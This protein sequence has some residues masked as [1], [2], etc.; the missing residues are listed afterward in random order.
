M[1]TVWTILNTHSHSTNLDTFNER[2]IDHRSPWSKIQLVQSSIIDLTAMDLNR[3]ARPKSGFDKKKMYFESN[4]FSDAA[5]RE[6]HDFDARKDLSDQSENFR[7]VDME[8]HD[9]G[10][11]IATNKSFVIFVSTSLN[12][13]SLR[14]VHI[15]ESNLLHA[16]KL[17]SLDDTLLIGLTDGSVKVLR[18]TSSNACRKSSDKESKTEVGVPFEQVNFNAKSCA[19]QNIIKEERKQFDDQAANDRFNPLEHVIDGADIGRGNRLINNQ[20]LLPAMS[21]NRDFVRWMD[22]SVN[23]NC[24]ISLC[25]ERLRVINIESTVEDQVGDSRE[26]AAFATMVL[27]YN[28]REYLVSSIFG[29]FFIEIIYDEKL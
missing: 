27:G 17:K 28:Q 2:R 7:C 21:S 13:G 14:K 8:Y 15:D 4:L 23:L 19:I 20:I 11:V 6:L 12:R 26:G 25:G 9:D 5:L 1:V 3:K 16:T 10:I 22:V 29:K 18:V 24:L